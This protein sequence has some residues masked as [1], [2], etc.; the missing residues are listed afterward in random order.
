MQITVIIKIMMLSLLLQNY[1]SFYDLTITTIDGTQKSMSDFKGKRVL[2]VIVPAT[3]AGKDISYLKNIDSLSRLYEKTYS[4]L[5]VPSYEY[6]HT[7]AGTTV[8][9]A[10][11][12][13]NIGDQVT[14]SKGVYT[15]KSSGSKQDALFQ[16][17]TNVSGNTH[18]SIEV[19]G[20]GQKYFINEYG[21]LFGVLS[22]ETTLSADLFESMNELQKLRD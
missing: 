2:I 11:Y 17:L 19:G 18:F 1:S 14:I 8:E 22:P 12:K 20:V 3:T 16:W 9:K 10:A 21:E 6:G 5:C 15:K 13:S 4:V 7:D